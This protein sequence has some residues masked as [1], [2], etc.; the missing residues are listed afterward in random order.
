MDLGLV[1][2]AHKRHREISERPRH[3]Q[4]ALHLPL[5]PHPP[6]QRGVSHPME[7]SPGPSMYAQH[8]HP[9]TWMCTYMHVSCMVPSSGPSG[10][11]HSGVPGSAPQPPHVIQ[12]YRSTHSV[13]SQASSR[14]KSTASARRAGPV[15]DPTTY[16]PPEG[17]LADPPSPAPTTRPVSLSPPCGRGLVPTLG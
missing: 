7:A 11:S 17:P 10:W 15:S 5:P 2:H 1:N 8:V 14:G 12:S 13:I 9:Y 4:P 3:C 16:P 6:D